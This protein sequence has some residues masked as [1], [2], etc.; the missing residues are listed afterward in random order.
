MSLFNLREGKNP[1]TAAV[2]FLL[3]KSLALGCRSMNCLLFINNH[4]WE[5]R[6]YTFFKFQVGEARSQSEEGSWLSWLVDQHPQPFA[7]LWSNTMDFWS[8]LLGE[9]VSVE[10]ARVLPI[11]LLA[12]FLPPFKPRVPPGNHEIRYLHSHPWV[13]REQSQI[14]RTGKDKMETWI[15]FHYLDSLS[16]VETEKQSK[17]VY[18]VLPQRNLEQ[19]RR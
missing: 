7:S 13:W 18:L 15:T 4:F 6:N 9:E 1:R 8:H 5:W 2:T 11:T 14:T 19:D 17:Y 3:W 12:T 10:P 16:V